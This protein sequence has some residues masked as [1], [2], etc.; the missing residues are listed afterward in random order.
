MTKTLLATAAM[1][2]ALAVPA[3]ASDNVQHDL[4]MRKSPAEQNAILAIAAAS[5]GY[6]CKVRRHTFKGLY[7]GD[8]YHLAECTNGSA[9]LI[10]L[11]ADPNGEVIVLDCEIAAAVGADCFAVWD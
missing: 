11:P 4:L 2:L 9:Y 8:A 5:A 3:Y 1:A 10:T 6:A 7:K